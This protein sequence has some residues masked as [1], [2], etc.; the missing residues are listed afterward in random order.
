MEII[1]PAISAGIFVKLFSFA[2]HVFQKIGIIAC[3]LLER[4]HDC[5]PKVS[6]IIFFSVSK[7]QNLMCSVLRRTYLCR[8]SKPNTMLINET[9]MLIICFHAMSS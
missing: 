8:L 5:S 6:A 3:I 1:S 9:I 4:H 2:D 7:P